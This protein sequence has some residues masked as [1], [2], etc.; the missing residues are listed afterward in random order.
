VTDLGQQ[1]SAYLD[2]E[3]SDD[4]ARRIEDLLDTD[5]AARSELDALMSANAAAQAEFEDML[6]DPAPLDIARIVGDI[7][8]PPAPASQEAAT[9]RRIPSWGAMAASAALI[10]AAA[11]GGYVAGTNSAPN[12]VVAQAGWLEDI[13]DYH[14]IYTTQSRHLVEVAADERDHIRDWLGAETGTTFSIPD[15]GADGLTFQGGRLLVAAG[16]PVAQLIYTDAGGAVIALCLKG[17]EKPDLADRTSTTID[18]FD[19]VSWRA[20]GADL[21]I[22]GPGGYSDLGQI[23]ENAADQ[24]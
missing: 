18:G 9:L 5:P 4:D 20:E 12:V 19:M 11:L 21:V 3:L 24:V 16:N 15:L 13:A 1:L 10:V 2:G 6:N 17:T 23:A 8:I 7:E 22:V 14:G